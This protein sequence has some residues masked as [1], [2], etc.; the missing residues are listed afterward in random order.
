MGKCSNYRSYR[1]K[2]EFYKLTWEW[3]K[4]MFEQRK[5]ELGRNLTTDEMNQVAKEIVEEQERVLKESGA[6]NIKSDLSKYVKKEEK[7]ESDFDYEGKYSWVIYLL[8]QS[9]KSIT[10]DN[11]NNVV[12]FTLDL[13]AINKYDKNELYKIIMKEN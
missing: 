11:V 9:K 1:K 3:S 5:D 8:K 4:L 6:V 2:N 7:S 10:L 13:S 12:S